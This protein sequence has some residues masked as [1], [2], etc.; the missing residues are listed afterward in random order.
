MKRTFFILLVLLTIS[1]TKSEKQKSNTFDDIKYFTKN[2]EN[3]GTLIKKELNQKEIFT[4]NYPEYAANSFTLIKFLSAIM[5]L[6]SNLTVVYL[7]LPKQEIDKPYIETI[8]EKTPLLGFKEFLELYEFMNEYEINFTGEFPIN[9]TRVLILSPSS[10]YE[11]IQKESFNKYEKDKVINIVMAGSSY[12]KNI[13]YII[14]ELPITKQTSAT[15]LIENIFDIMVML[16]EVSNYTPI[17]PIE[18]YTQ[19]NYLD[20]PDSF[21]EAN[22]SLI[23][24]IQIKK[25]NNYLPKLINNSFEELGEEIR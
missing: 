16:G 18:L 5:V 6:D 17:E 8:R 24:A 25:M 11:E 20:A 2:S 4:L 19:E 3:V 15:P 22:K 21:L 10:N 13:D 9:P 14:K 12:T 7:G 1:C 23:K